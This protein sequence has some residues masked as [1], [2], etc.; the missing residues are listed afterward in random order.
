[1]MDYDELEPSEFEEIED[2][3][4]SLTSFG[5]DFDVVG[6]VR[7]FINGSIYAPEFQRNYVWNLRKASKFIESLLLGLPVPGIFLFKEEE[8][9]KMLIIDGLQRLT[10]ISSYLNNNF[11]GKKFKLVGVNELFNNKTF[12]ELD[13]IQRLKLEDT[14]LHAT[15]IKPD[16]PKEKNTESIYLIFERLNTGGM[17]LSPQEIRNCIYQ[18]DFLSL[19]L[20]LGNLQ[21]FLD[22]LKIDTK[23]KKHEEICLR[24]LALTFRYEA[25]TGNMK[26]FL[27]SFLDENRNFEIV[28]KETISK[29]F[30]KTINIITTNI[31]GELFRLKKGPINLAILDSVFVGIANT[32]LN[33]K[34]IDQTKI[35]ENLESIINSKVFQET[36][37]TG[38]THHTDSVKKRIDQIKDNI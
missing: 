11:K 37:Q 6:L 26:S 27:N 9:Q 13:P 1:M 36:I 34:S 16:D 33:D 20:E 18:G 10:S 23:R 5:I 22:L 25:Y 19:I 29:V 35:K 2:F 32:I 21:Q 14:L 17:N 4:Y 7:R 12:E 24:L 30:T 38:K 3:Q 28:D 31:G 8:D 15:V